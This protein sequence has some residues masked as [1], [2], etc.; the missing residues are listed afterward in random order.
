MDQTRVRQEE[1]F[2]LFHSWWSIHEHLCVPR[3]WERVWHHADQLVAEGTASLG[4]SRAIDP[5]MGLWPAPCHQPHALGGDIM[6]VPH[7][8]FPWCPSFEPIVGPCSGCTPRM[9][10]PITTPGRGD[11]QRASA[12]TRLATVMHGAPSSMAKPVLLRAP[13]PVPAGSRGVGSLR[14]QPCRRGRLQQLWQAAAS[15]ACGHWGWVGLCLLPLFRLPHPRG[16][17]PRCPLPGH[18]EQAWICGDAHA[19]GTMPGIPQQSRKT[20]C[21]WDL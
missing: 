2:L 12:R 14:W 13:V 1:V 15:R 5:F 6:A 9:A 19:A 3:V 21:S 10:L 18:H 4:P 17:P 8:H 11:A 16:T 20:T 7:G